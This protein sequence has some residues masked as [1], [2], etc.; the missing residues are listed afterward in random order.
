MSYRA[1]VSSGFC[2]TAASPAALQAAAAVTAPVRQKQAI[3][4]RSSMPVMVS[5]SFCPV[6][7][8]VQPARCASAAGYAPPV[9]A[10]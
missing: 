4:I 7:A 10:G 5:A 2:A 8:G 9:P 6:A 3:R 1:S